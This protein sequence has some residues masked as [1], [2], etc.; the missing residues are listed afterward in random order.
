LIEP[1]EPEK[2]L[3]DSTRNINEASILSAEKEKEDASAL[4]GVP[5]IDQVD[6]A[7]LK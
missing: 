5:G 4:S 1:E 6:V 7:E 3:E 2:L